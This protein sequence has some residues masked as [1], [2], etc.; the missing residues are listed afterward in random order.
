MPPPLFFCIIQKMALVKTD[1]SIADIKGRLG[2]QY[3]S[4]DSAGLHIRSM[5]RVV[6]KEPTPPKKDQ[7]MFYGGLKREENGT[8]NAW[9]GIIKNGQPIYETYE[10]PTQ[11]KT[12]VIYSLCCLKGHRT[13]TLFEPE[14]KSVFEAGVNVI[15]FEQ[16]AQ[17]I[18]DEYWYFNG[19]FWLNRALERG[20]D[21]EKI[22]RFLIKAFGVFRHTEGMSVWLADIAAETLCYEWITLWFTAAEGLAFLT[23][24]MLAGFVVVAVLQQWLEGLTGQVSFKRGHCL[25]KIKE[26]L[27][28]GELYARP[29]KK[30]FDFAL[31]FPTNF[32]E[33]AWYMNPNLPN[34]RS[35]H[36][37]FFNT[38]TTI[39]REYAFYYAYDWNRFEVDHS[40]WAYEIRPGLYR[41]ELPESQVN[42][43]DVP[44]GWVNGDPEFGLWPYKIEEH[45]VSGYDPGQLC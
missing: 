24:M 17:R 14:W 1:N 44:V 42:Y 35:N 27:F 26:R 23:G 8:K 45:F 16:L 39:F 33:Y 20:V 30:M 41:A 36:F 5:P 6:R 9:G 13:P 34:Y 2:G 19:R 3:F 18:Y 11:D 28:W 38:Y 21:K 40:G 31:F 25:I 43:W 22:F 7:Q 10:E 32:P 12:A 37:C 4:R 29:S 15:Y